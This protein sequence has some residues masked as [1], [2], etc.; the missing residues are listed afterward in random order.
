MSLWIKREKT[1]DIAVLQCTGRIVRGESLRLLRDAVISLIQPRVVVLDLSG[2]K[3]LDCSGLGMLV[4]L[5][6]WTLEHGTRLTLVNPSDLVREMLERT[7]LTCV[8]HIS[9]V[10]DAV[11]ILCSPTENV[12]SHGSV[13]DPSWH[14]VSPSRESVFRSP[15]PTEHH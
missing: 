7:G 8:L 5:H 11:Q 6:C 1:S 14:Q 10:D 13:V 4:F 3:M 2:V 15:R 12:N 9:S